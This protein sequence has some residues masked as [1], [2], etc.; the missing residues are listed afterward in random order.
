MFAEGTD[1]H[2]YAVMIACILLVQFKLSLFEAHVCKTMGELCL[3]LRYL[4]DRN[5]LR[6]IFKYS[7]TKEGRI[8]L[9]EQLLAA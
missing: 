7:R 4:L 2:L 8:W 9:S 1:R 5:R 6:T 3:H